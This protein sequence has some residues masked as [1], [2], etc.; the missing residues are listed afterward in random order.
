MQTAAVDPHNFSNAN[1]VCVDVRI[2]DLIFSLGFLIPRAV[3]LCLIEGAFENGFSRAVG[4]SF[5]VT[6]GIAGRRGGADLS[7][8]GL[9]GQQQNGRRYGN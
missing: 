4:F 7:G 2:T 5:G 8:D 6:E 3:D 1:S 9:D